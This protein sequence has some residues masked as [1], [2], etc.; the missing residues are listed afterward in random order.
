[1]RIPFDSL[2]LACVTHELQVCRHATLEFIGEIDESTI[3]L[4]FFLEKEY[5]VAISSHPEF[6]R[7]L[8]LSR[9]PEL[10]KTTSSFVSTMLHRLK[11]AHVVKISQ[12]G[13]DRII[14]FS[15]KSENTALELICELMGKHSNLILVE[16][17]K[18]VAAQKFV[19]ASKSVRPILPGQPYSD[20]PFE[21]KPSIL[22]AT[23][24]DNLKD[25]DGA[26]PFLI[27]LVQS[28][29][30][31][32]NVQAAFGS[33]KFEPV[34]SPG[35][36]AYPISVETL[37]LK[38][39]ERPNLCTSLEIH[40]HILIESAE[41]VKTKAQL[42]GQLSRILLSREVAENDLTE[43]LDIGLRAPRLQ[44][45]GELILAHQRQI[46]PGDSEFKTL[47]YSGQPL[48]INLRSDL[49][50]I[51]N[52]ERIFKK[53]KSAKTRV[54]EVSAQ[55]TKIQIDISSLKDALESIEAAESLS[56]LEP[57]ISL[58]IA[59][60]WNQQSGRAQPQSERPYQG[61]AIKELEAPGGW[62]V[63]YGENST[64]NDY[65]TTKVA[66]PNDYWFHVRGG[67]SAHVVLCT[68]NQPTKVQTADLLFAAKV[69]I[70]QSSSKHSSYVSVDYTLKKYVR[71]PRKSAPGLA[72]YT[73]EKTLNINLD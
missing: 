43:A 50:A 22:K 14:R 27:R 46:R 58:C 44:M 51:E 52:A 45:M 10:Q 2:S 71:K 5:W 9:R 61:F 59:K 55:L 41:F 57:V 37:G 70:R 34:Y 73:H 66:K 38:C 63:L 28:G 35:H 36:G 39:F 64:S 42:K 20:P 30:P 24:S 3:C 21:P 15:F 23:P 29:V 69:A 6:A 18:I 19:G 72:V 56:D 1:M 11:G 25:F 12:V 16:G 68:Q 67:P 54:P 8:L 26:S 31:L 53:A 60:R 13:F 40:F 7:C 4:R 33:H 32:Q 62:K 48:R 47:D 49:T 65:L 17:T